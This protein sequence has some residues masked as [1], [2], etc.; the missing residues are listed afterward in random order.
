LNIHYNLFGVIILTYEELLVSAENMNLEVK[1]KPLQGYDGRIKGNRIAIRRDIATIKEKSCVLA[2]EIGHH[3]FNYGNIIDQSKTENRKQEMKAR[4]WAYDK[5][6][7]L[8]GLINAYN[9]GCR[10]LYEMAEHLD[11]T[12]NFL[13]DS[14]DS[15]RKKYGEY[16]VIDNYIIY[17]EPSL[18]IM[19]ML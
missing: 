16:I 1:E 10:N 8:I 13:K 6:V 3:L 15:Y 9:A 5:Q 7:G 12:E 18:G 11:V 17:F 19:K 2:E 14:L 4:Y